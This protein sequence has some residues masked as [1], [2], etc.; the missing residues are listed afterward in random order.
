MEATNVADAVDPVPHNVVSGCGQVV[1][2]SR[3]LY[4]ED[5]LE[6]ALHEETRVN[7]FTLVQVNDA[8]QLATRLIRVVLQ[9]VLARQLPLLQGEPSPPPSLQ[10]KG[11]NE[12]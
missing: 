12:N 6:L 2:A 9:E 7:L 10:T 3:G 11:E 8:L 1:S 5:V 4:I